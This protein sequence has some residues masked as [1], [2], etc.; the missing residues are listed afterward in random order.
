MREIDGALSSILGHDA[1]R[2]IYLIDIDMAGQEHHSTNGSHIVGETLWVG[3]EASLVAAEDWA[4]AQIRMFP[5]PTR[6]A[7][8][9][10]GG[11]RYR[12]ARVWLLGMQESPVAIEPGYAEEGYSLEGLVYADPLLLLDGQ[13]VGADADAESV[14]ID[15]AHRARIGQYAPRHRFAPPLANH[16]PQPG[17]VLVWEGEHYTLRSRFD[18]SLRAILQQIGART[19]AAAPPRIV[20]AVDRGIAAIRGRLS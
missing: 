4:A 5:T 10:S 11:W 8:V 2:P 3:G 20:R 9:V 7:S 19:R 16:L 15:I 17:Q 14:Y 1:T 12:S 18:P 13:M 6:V